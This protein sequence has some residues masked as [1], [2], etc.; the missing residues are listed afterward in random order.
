VQ[1]FEQASGVI[2]GAAA[3]RLRVH[4]GAGSH[5]SALAADEARALLGRL[6]RGIEDERLKPHQR[7][8]EGLLA[9]LR[10]LED[11]ISSGRQLVAEPW[12][13]SGTSLASSLALV[14]LEGD[15]KEF[16]ALQ[17]E[18]GK[19]DLSLARGFGRLSYDCPAGTDCID[20]ARR[21]SGSVYGDLALDADFRVGARTSIVGASLAVELSASGPVASFSLPLGDWLGVDRWIPLEAN[22]SVSLD[23]VSFSP[24]IDD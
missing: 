17:L 7:S 14:A 24:L 11:S 12:S 8:R 15:A 6:A 5:P 4:L 2:G 10:R 21:F 1:E 19:D 20:G 22:L 9:A 18:R 16:G 23:G 13:P 3:L